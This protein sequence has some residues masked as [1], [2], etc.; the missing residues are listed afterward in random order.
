[1]LPILRW[2]GCRSVLRT[3]LG[4]TRSLAR[5]LA[6]CPWWLANPNWG[7]PNQRYRV[8]GT[9]LL[10]PLPRLHAHLSVIMRSLASRSLPLALRWLLSLRA[11]AQLLEA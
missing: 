8:W 4:V 7:R 2:Q 3:R 1:M 11:T 5:G 9:P 10:Y 6:G